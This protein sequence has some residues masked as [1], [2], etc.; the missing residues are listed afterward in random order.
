MYLA[1]ADGNIVT[2]LSYFNGNTYAVC[3]MV[4]CKEES[5]ELLRNKT[6]PSLALQ[7]MYDM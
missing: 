3:G 5:S 4:F 7:L 6:L 2:I 1:V